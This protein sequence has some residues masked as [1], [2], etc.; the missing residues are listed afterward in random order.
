MLRHCG[1]SA[2][3]MQWA[4]LGDGS[5]W[6]QV[7]ALLGDST[8]AGFRHSDVDAV[9]NNSM[10]HGIPRFESTM[11]DGLLYVRATSKHSQG[12]SLPR[13][14]RKARSGQRKR[15]HLASSHC[16]SQPPSSDP[17]AIHIRHALLGDVG[18]AP[19]VLDRTSSVMVLRSLVAEAVACRP[20][21]VCLLHHNEVI[22]H[23]DNLEA[24]NV[25]ADAELQ[26]VLIEHELVKLL[27]VSHK[28]LSQYCSTPSTEE[29]ERFV[30]GGWRS[31][32]DSDTVPCAAKDAHGNAKGSCLDFIHAQAKGFS[33]AL[34]SGEDLTASWMD[35]MSS[36]VGTWYNIDIDN[37]LERA[38]AGTGLLSIGM[39]G[40]SG[41]ENDDDNDDG[42]DRD[43]HRPETL[44]WD[45]IRN[46]FR[47]GQE[48]E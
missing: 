22:S 10:K 44:S 20:H 26:V 14:C 7:D 1:A 47:A 25:D 45:E 33:D 46:F 5:L 28:W 16:R 23:R 38:Q 18:C 12:T 2:K 30:Q 43:E 40:D 15:R 13:S 31:F 32:D 36:N 42:D 4:D 3:G 27:E 41:E 34:D 39:F 48:Y 8:F 19:I 17:I 9:V 21:Q 6:F 24:A 35:G 29:F 11:I 37:F